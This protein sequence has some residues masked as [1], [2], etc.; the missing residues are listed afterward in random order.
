MNARFA[1]VRTSRALLLLTALFLQPVL[2]AIPGS[3]KAALLQAVNDLPP[4]GHR[5]RRDMGR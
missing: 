1:L 3:G 2:A 4:V 5:L